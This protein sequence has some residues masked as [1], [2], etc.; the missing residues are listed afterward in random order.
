MRTIRLKLPSGLRLI[1][2][3][4]RLLADIT[5]WGPG[6]HRQRFGI[7]RRN[8]LTIT[9]RTSARTA[10]IVVSAPALIASSA[11]VLETQRHHV[12]R[13]TFVVGTTQSTGALTWLQLRL[14]PR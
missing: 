2:N 11:I 14:M 13:L 3:R 5:V 8:G 4:A 9:L 10:S 1:A 6:H 7:S 12:G